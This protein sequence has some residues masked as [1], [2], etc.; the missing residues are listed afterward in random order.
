MII[1][2]SGKIGSGKDTVGKIIQYLT[3]KKTKFPDL[4][5]GEDSFLASSY[6][7]DYDTNIEFES[8]W[9]IKKF[10][11]KLKE[12]VALLLGL[13]RSDLEKEEIKNMVLGPEW[14]RYVITRQYQTSGYTKEYLFKKYY[15]LTEDEAED[16][17]NEMVDSNIK[18][19][20]LTVRDLLQQIGTDAMRNV[21][22]PNIWLNALFAD[23]GIKDL[24]YFKAYPDNYDLPNWIITDVR[25][26][27]EAQAIKDRG[28]IIIRVN[29]HTSV[30]EKTKVHMELK[31]DITGIL[32][33]NHSS[34]TE[35][36]NYSFDYT[37]ENNGSIEEL[38]NKVKIILHENNKI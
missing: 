35:L 32:T 5:F 16:F 38:I 11:D 12:I 10:A 36:N 28:G 13:Q 17:Y 25:F 37:I 27:N 1:G 3:T 8:G 4:L 20:S 9:K 29:R 18:K 31:E 15:F 6:V 34:E 23:Y 22:H 30:P 26:P 2:I 33:V 14:D 21:I 19:E 7:G 24:N